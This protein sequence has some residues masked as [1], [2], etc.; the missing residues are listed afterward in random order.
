[1]P[2]VSPLPTIFPTVPTATIERRDKAAGDDGYGPVRLGKCQRK[3]TPKHEG[4]PCY[5][6]FW[7]KP[8]G[9]SEGYDALALPHIECICGGAYPTVPEGGIGEKML[10]IRDGAETDGRHDYGEMAGIIG[11]I[12]LFTFIFLGL[13]YSRRTAQLREVERRRNADST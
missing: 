7:M 13:A 6:W 11:A 2:V 10:F 1:M 8:F 3:D 9:A 4:F 12:F 5:K